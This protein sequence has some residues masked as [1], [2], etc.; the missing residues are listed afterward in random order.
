MGC[1]C[2]E[3]DNRHGCIHEELVS[4]RGGLVANKTGEANVVG[5]HISRLLRWSVSGQGEPGQQEHSL[6]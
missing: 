5:K 1:A 6:I 3:K 4:R 2:R